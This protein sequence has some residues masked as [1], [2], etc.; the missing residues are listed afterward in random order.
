MVSFQIQIA[1][2][3]FSEVR[4]RGRG[5]PKAHLRSSPVLLLTRLSYFTDVAVK[6]DLEPESEALRRRFIEMSGKC[7]QQNT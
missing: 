2:E 5:S 3:K 6:V 7:D 1:K 4:N